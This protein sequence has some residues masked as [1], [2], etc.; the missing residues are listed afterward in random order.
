MKDEVK[1]KICL[2]FRLQV[3][4]MVW[5]LYCNARNYAINLIHCTNFLC[6]KRKA[7]LNL[8]MTPATGFSGYVSVHCLWS[9]RQSIQGS[10]P[11]ETDISSYL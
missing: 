4:I 5:L 8:G 6:K 9:V 10:V 7:D 3:C 2:V 1:R 11:I